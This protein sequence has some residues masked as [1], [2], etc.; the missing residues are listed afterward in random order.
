[1]DEDGWMEME[2]WTNGWTGGR[3]VGWMGG[4]AGRWTDGR[5]DGYGWME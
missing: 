3:V 1:M 2:G 4:Q 5:V